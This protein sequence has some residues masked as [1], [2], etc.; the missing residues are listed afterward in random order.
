MSS[1]QETVGSLINKLAKTP[2][3][4]KQPLPYLKKQND[5]IGFLKSQAP[6]SLRFH[7]LIWV[8]GTAYWYHLKPQSRRDTEVIQIQYL[9]Y[10][11]KDRLF[12]EGIDEKDKDGHPFVDKRVFNQ[13]PS[14]QNLR[15]IDVFRQQLA[16]ENNEAKSKTTE[17]KK[18]KKVKPDGSTEEDGE[19]LSPKRIYTSNGFGNFVNQECELPTPLVNRNLTPKSVFQLM[20]KNTDEIMIPD[21]EKILRLIK[22]AQNG[23]KIV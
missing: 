21:S 13:H 15:W 11:F 14:Q 18:G 22:W 7:Y 8:D 16:D 10:F 2:P 17:K 23:Y 5:I 1:P 9:Y 20:V 12:T 4:Q 6:D 19:F 3:V